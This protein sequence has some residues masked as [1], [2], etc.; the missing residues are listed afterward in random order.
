MPGESDSEGWLKLHDAPP[1]SN[2]RFRQF[3]GESDFPLIVSV[4]NGM[5]EADQLELTTTVED[6]AREF[7]HMEHCDPYRDFLF[8]EV[9]GKVIGYTRIWWNKDPSGIYLYN[10]Y[11]DFLPEW[12]IEGIRNAMLRYNERKLREMAQTHP[13]DS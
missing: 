8:A 4:I 12:R 7:R 6:I 3:R 11:V 9:D 5:K 1:I 2:L 10:H 13:A